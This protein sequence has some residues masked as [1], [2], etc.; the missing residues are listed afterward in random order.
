MKTVVSCSPMYLQFLGHM[1]S[2]TPSPSAQC[3]CCVTQE[4]KPLAGVIYDAYNGASVM[5]HIWVEDLFTPSR[6]WIAAIFDYPFNRMEVYKI[7]GQVKS[8]NT[9]A[10]ALDEHFGF[11]LE[12]IIEGFYEEGHSLL[13]YTMTRDQC[14]VLNSPRWA[15]VIERVSRA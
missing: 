6:D 11:E 8:T 15:K 2:Y 10:I 7:I 9:E 1:L 5:A 13:V 4:G 14:R 3:I 12:G